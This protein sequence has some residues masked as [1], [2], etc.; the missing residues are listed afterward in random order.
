M[1]KKRHTCWAFVSE[2]EGKRPLGRPSCR[3]DDNIKTDLKEIDWE[4][5]VWIHLVHD[6]DKGRTIVSTLMNI[7]IS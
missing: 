2:S 5:V 4:G 1:R 3:W 7:L 6:R